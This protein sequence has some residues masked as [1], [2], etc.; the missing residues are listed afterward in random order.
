MLTNVG[1]WGAASVDAK[2][3]QFC[4][5]N[6]SIPLG[7]KAAVRRSQA[8]CLSCQ[9][10]R[11]TLTTAYFALR[12]INPAAGRWLLFDRLNAGA[13]T[14]RAFLFND[15]RLYSLHLLS[16]PTMDVQCFVR[17]DSSCKHSRELTLRI[18]VKFNKRP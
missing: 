5:T 6:A 9:L 18:A 1:L 12:R 14:G 8:L 17:L 16:K 7:K 3:R 13:T 2:A 15:L 4:R 10:F 11:P